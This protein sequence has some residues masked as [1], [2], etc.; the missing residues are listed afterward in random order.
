MTDEVKPLA[1]HE[2]RLLRQQL[3]AAANNGLMPPVALRTIRR[4]MAS[5]D[6]SRA[7]LVRI[8]GTRVLKF[9][10]PTPPPITAEGPD[11]AA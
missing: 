10:K 11:T 1:L 5:L 8:T 7:E 6:A 3:D 9:P 4:L 2:E